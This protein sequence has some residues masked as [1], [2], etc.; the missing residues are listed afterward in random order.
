MTSKITEKTFIDLRETFISRNYSIRG[1]AVGFNIDS[2]RLPDGNQAKREYLDHPGAV[3]VIP[4]ISRDKIVM[5]QQFRYPVREVTWEIP[6]GKLSPEENP[7]RCVHREL[8]EETGYKAKRIRR[9]ISFWPTPAFANE[10]IHIYVATGL[11]PGKT[12]LDSDEFL[13]TEIWP[14]QK[15]YKAIRTGEIKDSKTIIALLALKALKP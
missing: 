10:I 15:A 11:K 13:R 5:V 7:E 2:V 1:S 9:I 6:A 4:Q 3:A 14:L 12:N 8:A